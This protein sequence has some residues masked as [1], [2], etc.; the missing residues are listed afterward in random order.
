MRRAV[1]LLIGLGCLLGPLLAVYRP[2]LFEDRQFAWDN[3][4]YYYYPLYLRVKQEWEAGRLPLW[5][6]GQN[7][8]EPMLGNPIA[9]VLYPGKVLHVL[10]SYAWGARLYVIA[11]TII[12]LLG[13]LA[14]GRSCGVSWVGS[15]LGGLSYAFGAP[16]LFL[17]CNVV[18]KVGAAW[19]PWG[20]SAIDHLLRRRGRGG[21]GGVAAVLTLQVLGGDPEAAYLTAVCGALYALV[22]TAGART[23]LSGL[24]T[25]PKM[26]GA[27]CFWFAATLGLDAARIVRPGFLATNR[28][29]LAAWAMV[30]IGIAWRWHRR[31]DENL[32]AP[33]LARLAG[34]YALAVALAAV[35]VLP[36][37]EFARQSWR[38]AGITASALYNY[39]LHPC[40]VAELAWPG[41]FGT[42]SFENR[43]W[44]QAVPPAGGHEIWVASL[45]MGGLTLALALS[46]FG[47]RSGTPWR[48]WLTT[49]V[50]VALVG[51]FGKF[52]GPL[53]WVRWGPFSAVLGP[54]DPGPGQPRSD[55]FLVDGAGSP[56]GLLAVLLPGFGTFRYPSKLLPFA[57]VGL[58]VLAGVGWDGATEAAA[59]RRLRRI[60][61]AGLGVSLVGLALALAARDGAVAFLAGRVP[62]ETTF[63]PVDIAGAWR[64]T[65][66]GLAHGAIVFAAVL[67]LAQWAPSRP[68]AA[69]ALA[70]VLLA[71]DLALANARLICTV[72]QA[73]FDAP[74]EAARQI[75]AAERSDPSPGPFRIHRMTGSYPIH[76]STAG[77]ADRFRGMIAWAR[78]TLYPLH[79]LPLALEYCATTGTLELDD[80]AA[81]FHPQMMSLPA[82][83][84]QVLGVPP[85]R[86]VVYHPRRSFDI[87]GA[88]YLL[89]PAVPD[90]GSPGRGFASFLNKTDLI[91]PSPEVL[92]ERRYR[93]GQEPWGVR[94][95]W[96]LRRN[97]AAYPR[98]WVVHYARI[99]PPATDPDARSSLLRT[100]VFMNDP[101]WKENNRPV[102]DLRQAALIETDDEAALQGFSSRTPVGPTESVAVVNH[103]PQRIELRASLDRPGLVI[104]ADTYYPGWRLTIDGRPTPI[105]RANRLMRGAAVPSGEHTLV[106]TYEPTSFRVGAIISTAG[107]IA[108]LA[109]PL[110]SRV[111]PL[112]VAG[113]RATSA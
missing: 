78:G 33:L 112:G 53:W 57:A 2:V 45:Y 90:W 79:G 35:Q 87:W 74:S 14:L 102:F 98:A 108:L 8:G 103:E 29:V 94:E 71:V 20:L 32:L 49:V 61:L 100:L 69:G 95:D 80:H 110:R 106:Y 9:A 76:F 48:T 47:W 3:A 62:P 39:S 37:L 4:S 58:S 13:L 77:T 54:H 89:L 101:I 12:A 88:R 27:V 86:P 107:L 73:E 85:G 111:R 50:A 63:G 93:T 18:F 31:P 96:Q 25:W 67:A 22:L 55:H 17:Y 7:G 52:G 15:F 19:I 83:M 97:R 113:V 11:H 10:P 64:E 42:G 5:D 105:F 91:Y 41:V 82:E 6:P 81:I 92:Y 104:L 75:E 38:A 36:A 1:L 30:G 60:G 59:T 43:S 40:R 65:Q 84:A 44:L 46:A 51:S 24:F 109:L 23:R 66:R 21:A 72:P 99:R 34:A 26:L 70:I 28:L 68:R 16:V 56:Y